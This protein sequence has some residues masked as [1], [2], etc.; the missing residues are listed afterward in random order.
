MRCSGSDSGLSKCTCL[1]SFCKRQ[2]ATCD[3]KNGKRAGGTYT[4]EHLKHIESRPLL[5][6]SFASLLPLHNASCLQK[7]AIHPLRGERI[8]F[9]ICWHGLPPNYLA[10]AQAS[11][12][13]AE[14]K[15]PRIHR[16]A[17]TLLVSMEVPETIPEDPPKD[18]R[19][20]TE[21]LPGL[22]EKSSRGLPQKAND[23][24]HEPPQK[25]SKTACLETPIAP[26]CMFL[27]GFTRKPHI[28]RGPIKEESRADPLPGP[29]P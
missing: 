2:T 13:D 15:I 27:N 11:P 12:R 21:N 18:P 6:R 24:R 22:P 17:H 16:E 23:K 25:A 10:C 19:K 28:R 14:E 3:S 9:P 1:N 5:C 29:L 7:K 8:A 20:A 4:K 26:I